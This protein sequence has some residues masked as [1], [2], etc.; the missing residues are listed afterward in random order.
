MKNYVVV[1]SE[2][3][4]GV[5]KVTGPMPLRSARA[6]VRSIVKKVNALYPDEE[7]EEQMVLTPEGYAVSDLCRVEVVALSARGK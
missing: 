2:I 4:M 1:E 5:L 3:D 7:S 6:L